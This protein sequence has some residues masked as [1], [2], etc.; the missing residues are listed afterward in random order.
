MTCRG[1][2]AAPGA[3]STERS[4]EQ[5][6]GDGLVLEPTIDPSI[7]PGPSILDGFSSDPAPLVARLRE[8]DPVCWLAG[9]DAWIVTRHE[10]V[11]RLSSEPRLTADPRAFCRYKAP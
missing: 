9:L 10:D 11:R 8:Q 2:C 5:G 6:G 3:R 1:S 7:L 4:T